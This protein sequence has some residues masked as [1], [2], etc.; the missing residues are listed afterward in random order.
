MMHVDPAITRREAL[1]QRRAWA[2]LALALVAGATV[3]VVELGVARILTPV[4]GGS[5]SIWVIVIA[6]TMLAL[7][8][9]YAIGGHWADRYGG[10]VVARGAAAIGALLC[11][12]IPWVRVP[13]IE[14]TIDL[15]TL[16]GATVAATVLIAPPLFFLSQVSPALIRGLSA[17]DMSHLGGTAGGIYA[18][19]TV[20]SLLGT[21]GAV[22]VFLYAPLAVG[23]VGSALLLAVPLLF[24]RP[25][26]GLGVA[27]IVASML[28]M[29]FGQEDEL[30]SGFNPQGHFCTLVAKHHSTY[31]EI[32]I[33]EQADRYRYMVVNG[34]DQGGIELPSGNSADTFD[35]GLI[36]LSQLYVSSP[37]NALIIGLGSGLVVKALAE[38]G[39][40]VDV[41]EIDPEVVRAAR[42]YFGYSGSPVV[43]DGRRYLQRTEKRWDVI[44][45][46][47]FLDGNPPWQLYT[48]EAF[49]LYRDHLNP[50]GIVALNFIGSH[51]DPEQRP[52]LEAVVAT[53]REVFS[54]ADA[55]PDPWQP[56]AY[57]TRNVFI[58]AST[59]PR[60]E[61]R[62][63]GDPMST[64]GV[65]SEALAR[66]APTLIRSGRILTDGSAPLA[67]L[68]R[69]TTDILRSRVREYLPLS[70][71]IR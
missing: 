67:P 42:D 22:W 56:D 40:R 39:V 4:F 21:L 35:K 20:G 6:T 23:F 53:A 17:A 7:A 46:D 45:V 36:G 60:I 33:I 10:L 58:A 15:P 49:E 57:P 34:T 14:A 65:M 30:V 38:A 31:G 70:V 63:P 66:S 41:V 44:F 62:H 64:D 19:S 47:A 28:A 51:L 8:A 18:L 32:R 1:G 13:L 54:T 43:D 37:A 52:A 16:S 69:R 68:V 9:G 3:M 48:R 61:P 50:G 55:Y 71:L 59:H 5:I 25:A 26:T 12:A 2:A 29:D 11:A 24:L 27:A